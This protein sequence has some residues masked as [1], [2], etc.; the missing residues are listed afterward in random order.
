MGKDET[1][2]GSRE[3]SACHGPVAA[4]L[5]LRHGSEHQRHHRLRAARAPPARIRTEIGLRFCGMVEEEPRPATWGSDTSPTSVCES[6]AVSVANLA[7][8][9][10]MEAEGG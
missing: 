5:V 9:P 4:F 1:P 3:A 7:R 2:V 8:L 6:R 10:E